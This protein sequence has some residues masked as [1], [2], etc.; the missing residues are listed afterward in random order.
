MAETKLDPK[1]IISAGQANQFMYY[2]GTQWSSIN[3]YVPHII[4]VGI[5]QGKPVANIEFA[6]YTAV[7][8]VTIDPFSGSIMKGSCRVNPTAEATFLIKKNGGDYGSCRFNTNGTITD[9]FSGSNWNLN[10]GDTLTFHTPTT[11]DATLM[12]IAFS[13]KGMVGLIL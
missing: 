6:R 1:Q 12:D 13:I 7:V 8:P 3:P 4:R 10:A 11:Q 2:D 9:S 5:S